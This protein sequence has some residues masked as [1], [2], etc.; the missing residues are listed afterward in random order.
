MCRCG[1]IAPEKP[2]SAMEL[3]RSRGYRQFSILGKAFADHLQGWLGLRVP[4]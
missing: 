3:Q 4:L 1:V 2:P